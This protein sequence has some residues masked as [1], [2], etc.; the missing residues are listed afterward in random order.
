MIID[1]TVTPA[2]V[3]LLELTVPWDAA[4]NFKAACDRKLAQYE[5]LALDIKEN[6]YSVANMP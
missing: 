4:S 6:G 5:R 1:R 2:K 3:V